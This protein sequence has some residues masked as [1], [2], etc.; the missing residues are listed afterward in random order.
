VIRTSVNDAVYSVVIDRPEKRNALTPEMQ[1]AM[2]AAVRGLPDS[3]RVLL[4]RGEGPVFC[5][6]FDLRLCLEKPGT[7]R[8]LLEGLAALVAALKRAP[9]PV[10]CAAHGAAIAGGCALLGGCDMVI[11]DDGARLGYPVTPLGISPAVSAPF[12]RLLVGDGCSRERQLDPALV[13]G[14]RAVAIGLAHESLPT[15][16]AVLERATR[17]AEDLAAKP[18]WAL[19]STR[20]WLLEIEESAAPGRAAALGLDAS[21]ALVGS[22]E[23]RERLSALFR[24]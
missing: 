19:A 22:A 15:A 12:L 6:G 3:A 20:S 5:G 24:K 18:A 2:L 23:E 13:S 4:L 8:A 1:D 14:R 7:L 16:E 17:V 11:T 10:V 21:L 9:V